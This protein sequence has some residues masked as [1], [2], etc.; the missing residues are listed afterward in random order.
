MKSIILL[1]LCLV[2]CASPRRATIAPEL[3]RFTHCDTTWKEHLQCARMME[4]S[5]PNGY[6]IIQQVSP[7]RPG[8]IITCE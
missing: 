8:T 2:G 3:Y 7:H 4:E 6:K 5:C 1:T